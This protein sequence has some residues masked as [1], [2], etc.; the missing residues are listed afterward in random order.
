MSHE[1]SVLGTPW[2]W[3]V[4][5]LGIGQSPQGFDVGRAA[6]VL[7]VSDVVNRRFA[8]DSHRFVDLLVR[9]IVSHCEEPLSTAPRSLTERLAGLRPPCD[10]A[11]ACALLIESLAKCGLIP[12]EDHGLQAHWAASLRRISTML[13]TTDAERYRN[14]HLLVGLLH[15]AGQAGWTTALNS[16]AA[17]RASRAAWNLADSTE[18]PFYRARGAAV[19]IAVLGALGQEQMLWHDGQDR[20]A[21]LIGLLDQEFQRVP[22]RPPDGVHEGRDYRLFPLLLTLAAVGETGRVDCLSLHRNWLP[23]SAEEM[24]AVSAASRASQSLFWVSALQN[25]AAFSHLRARSGL[26]PADTVGGYLKATDGRRADDYLRCTYLIHLANRLGRPDLLPQRIWGILMQSLTDVVGSGLHR[27]NS[28]A[29]GFMIVAYA[30]SAMNAGGP[31]PTPAIDLA[32]VALRIEDDP[33]ALEVQLPRLGF[34]LVDAALRLRKPKSK[35]TRPFE[36]VA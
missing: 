26:I 4:H 17:M 18:Q 5:G 34:S 36:A 20:V 14:L 7:A 35:G 3:L 30:L 13:A 21:G 10:H 24:L 1:E 8:S 23:L 2:H 15:A 19:L 31:D 22:T 12:P 27:E 11:R 9:T 25:L 28:Y 32:E 6:H 33:A 16:P 29:S